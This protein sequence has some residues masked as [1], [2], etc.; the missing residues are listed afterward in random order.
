M[1]IGWKKALD[2]LQR[3]RRLH[4]DG[5]HIALAFILSCL[6]CHHASVRRGPDV[7]TELSDVATEDL[8]AI[9]ISFGAAGDFLRAE[10]YLNA[11]RQRGY[12]EAAVVYWLVRVCVAA[13]RYESALRHSS[14]YLRRHPG[15]WPLRLVLASIHEALGDDSRAR[16]ELERIVESQ[17]VQAL[18]HY[19]LALVYLRQADGR[20]GAHLEE[21]LRLAPHGSHAAEVR[22]LLEQG[23]GL[24]KGS[25]P[26]LLD[27][28]DQSL[29]GAPP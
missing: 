28:Q 18:P 19:R 25:P 29:G 16:D 4:S 22:S 3:A 14:D 17:P 2:G 11:A 9:G 12:E 1:S 26:L 24:P 20:A 15:D 21:Y 8:F 7:A 6:G 13:S 23:V 27:T 5:L 10:Q